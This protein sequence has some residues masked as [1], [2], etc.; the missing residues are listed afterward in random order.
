MRELGGKKQGK[1]EDQEKYTMHY[2]LS[3]YYMLTS[4]N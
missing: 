3:E 4:E 1:Q 2:K